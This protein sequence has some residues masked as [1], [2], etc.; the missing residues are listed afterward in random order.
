MRITARW[1]RQCEGVQGWRGLQGPHEGMQC[2]QIPISAAVF[3]AQS[4]RAAH[5]RAGAPS[6]SSSF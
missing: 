2:S 3:C 6:T 1:W 5:G 4:G